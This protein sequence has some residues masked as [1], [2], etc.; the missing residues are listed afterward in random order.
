MPKT[1]TPSKVPQTPEN[2]LRTS[3]VDTAREGWTNR[4]IDLSRRNNLLYYKPT[5]TTTLE[6]PVTQEM[7]SFLSDG[8]PLLITDLL[9]TGHEKLSSV[10]AI[11]RKGLENLEEKG[12]STLYLA[13]GQCTWAATDGGRDPISPIFLIP[14]NLKLK[15]QNLDATEM[16]IAGDFEVNPVLLHVFNREL[17][18]PLKAE[19]LLDLFTS[20]QPGA[21]EDEAETSQTLLLE[22]VLNFLYGTASKL[23]GFKAEPFAILGN[24]SFQK[25][26]MVR[27][28]ENHRPELI[29]ND[30]VAAIAGDN[31]AR[32]TLGSTQISTDPT[33][34][35]SILPENEDAVVEA[36]SSQQCALFGITAGQHAVIHGP[37]GT[38]KSQTITNLI[39]TLA[40]N[41]K[42]VLFVAE[43]RAALEVVMSRLVAVGLDHLAIDLH[44]AEQTPKKVME[45]IART[46]SMV[47]DAPKPASSTI[48]EQFSDRRNKLNQHDAK[49]HTVHAPAE[50]TVYAMQGTL[51]RLPSGITSPLRW[52]GADL[53]QIT[54]KRAERVLDL[55]GEAAGFETL[56]NRSDPS[57]WTGVELKDGQ[58]VQDAVDLTDRLTHDVIPRLKGSL[59]DLSESSGLRQPAPMVETIQLLLLLK[60]TDRLL[61][62]YESPVFIE[63]DQLLSYML[64]CQASGIRG[65]WLRLTNTA[66]K[67]AHKKAT[68]L[69]RGRKARWTTTI[70]ELSEAM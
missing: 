1:E 25:L 27:D 51:L 23:P 61:T 21:E 64:P 44:G 59:R 41:G 37:P 69:R 40:A 65:T 22:P 50:E 15:G 49:M 9:G 18:L 63:A 30:V 17:N 4:L 42:K 60:Q 28:L 14:V 70:A 31:G 58:A 56:F 11:A 24:F 67:T 33:T 6:L 16:Q 57:P 12:L 47:R 2:L 3:L 38:G 13:F 68:E 32:R 29:T 43:K 8:G 52:R 5:A 19:T 34:L 45:R 48:H 36:D 62:I 53:M 10:R 46:L 7:M 26:A 55:L 35:D 66:Y 20:Q 39:A 54:R